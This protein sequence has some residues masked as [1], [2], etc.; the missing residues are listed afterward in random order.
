MFLLSLMK[1][2]RFRPN[3]LLRKTA[4]VEQ[5]FFKCLKAQSDNKPVTIYTAKVQRLRKPKK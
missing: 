4:K 2:G 1:T 5:I 3:P